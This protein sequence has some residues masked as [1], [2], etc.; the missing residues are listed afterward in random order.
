MLYDNMKTV[1]IDRDAYGP[2][3]HRFHA[4]LNDFAGHSGFRPGLCRP[5]RAQT[6]GKVERFIRYLRG[7]LVVPFSSRMAQD[8]LVVDAPAANAAVTRWLRETANARVH[9]T[10]GAVPAERLNEERPALQPI[11]APWGGTILRSASG[12]PAA[13][14]SPCGPPPPIIGL[15]HPLSV[16]EALV[17]A[18]GAMAGEA[19]P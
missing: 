8:G 18:S 3:K 7:R 11:P 19:R 16:Y 5:Y 12:A 6:K 1:V 13:R 17:P 9:A 10:T 15:Q 2:G 4:A 14:S